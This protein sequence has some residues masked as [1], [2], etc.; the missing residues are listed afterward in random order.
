MRKLSTAIVCVL[1]ICILTY[2]Y[3]GPGNHQIAVKEHTTGSDEYDVII[4]GAGMAGLAAADALRKEGHDVL[5]LE[6][7]NRVGGR[8]WTDRTLGLPLDMGAGWIQGSKGNPMTKFAKDFGLETKVT[9]WDNVTL[10]NE[11]GKEVDGEK[12]ELLEGYVEGFSGYVDQQ[13]EA[14]DRDVPLSTA[15]DDFIKQKKLSREDSLALRNL[16]GLKIEAEYGADASSLS[17]LEFD[18]DSQL[19]GEELIILQGYDQIP[20]RLAKDLPIHLNEAVKAITYDDRGVTVRTNSATYRAAH[21]IVTVPLGVLKNESIAFSPAL[22]SSKQ[23]AIKRLGM[24]VADKVYLVFPKVFWKNDEKVDFVEFVSGNT[25]WTGFLNYY[26]YSKKPVIMIFNPGD[27][28]EEL[29]KESDSEIVHKAMTMLRTIYGDNIPEPTGYLLTRW[30]QDP[31]SRGA[32]SYVA[33]GASGEDYDE[34]AKPVGRLHFAGE[35][36]N[37]KFPALVHGAYWSG[38]RAAKEIGKK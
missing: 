37:R 35:A 24:G 31:Y 4:I 11:N 20:Q 1:T 19:K 10:Y 28:A 23:K 12:E 25:L 13:Q 2:L 22:P 6:A 38:L 29:E 15:I 34:M 21:A 16:I 26:K 27:E 3:A 18:Q 36:T 8:V 30:G 5:V 17:L 33:V 14:R 9:D 32:Y 7:R